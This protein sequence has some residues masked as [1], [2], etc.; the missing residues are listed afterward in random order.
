MISF[1]EVKVFLKTSFKINVQ[2]LIEL[3]YVDEGPRITC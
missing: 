1:V 3:K 2:N